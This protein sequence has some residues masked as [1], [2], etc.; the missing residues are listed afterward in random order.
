MITTT[1]ILKRFITIA[2]LGLSL[3]AGAI[4]VLLILP[5]PTLAHVDDP[6][7]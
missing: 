3:I 2:G 6:C 5:D 1:D 7:R 4:G